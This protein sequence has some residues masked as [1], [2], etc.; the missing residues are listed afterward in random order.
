[1]SEVELNEDEAV[2]TDGSIYV[3]YLTPGGDDQAPE[4][5][6]GP[7]VDPCNEEELDG[8]L[9]EGLDWIVRHQEE[10]GNWSFA[11][12]THPDCNGQCDVDDP[13]YY[14]DGVTLF[15]TDGSMSSNLTGATGLALLPLLGSGNTLTAGSYRENVC[16]GVNYLVSKQ[17]GDGN[18]SDKHS[19][20][21]SYDHLICHL[22]L[23][24][25]YEL[26]QLASTQGCPYSS[27]GC[28]VDLD[29]LT[30][31]V[32]K[33]VDFTVASACHPDTP[34]WSYRVMGDATMTT[35]AV[36][37]LHV[38]ERAGLTV[39]SSIW[40]EANDFLTGVGVDGSSVSGIFTE[41]YYAPGNPLIRT[42]I[43]ACAHLS[44]I[45]MGT[46]PQHPA[47]T[48]FAE[49]VTQAQTTH[50]PIYGNM[51]KTHLKY[52]VGGQQWE[53]WNTEMRNHLLPMQATSGHARGSFAF[54]QSIPY[55]CQ[56]TGGR[57]ANTAMAL[58][59]L[60]TYFAGLR[61]DEN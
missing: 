3:A 41:N 56:Q 58:L 54:V 34:G 52:F 23:A 40:D 18:L 16:K 11:H 13:K 5:Y 22:A 57:L 44:H 36:A 45:Y 35:W 10:L 27:S 47:I 33:A 12:S 26:A 53:D 14:A 42:E 48:Q 8:E 17:L 6:E 21:S 43:T 4:V 61:L 59:T 7:G 20:I 29:D 46:S 2:H 15:P 1:M 19:G 38:S 24:E 55:N 37:A 30:A 9:N 32:Q 49:S 50:W 28:D 60:E 31:A 39:P 25:A 51:H